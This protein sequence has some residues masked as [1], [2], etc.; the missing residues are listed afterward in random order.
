M[1]KVFALLLTLAMVLSLMAGCGSSSSES[2]A[3]ESTPAETAEAEVSEEEPEEPEAEEP[4]AEEPAAEEPEAPAEE[5]EAPAEEAPEEEAEEE[6]V[7]EEKG[8]FTPASAELPLA[9]N[10]SLTYF[11]ELPGYMSMFNVNSYDDINAF[12]YA[13]EITGIDVKFTIVNSESYATNFQLMVASGDILDMVAGASDQYTSTSAMI[14]DGVALDLMEYQDLL[15]NYF[16]ALDYYSDYWVAALNQEGQMPEAITMADDY[17]VSAGLQT[18]AD[19]LDKLGM[20]A[21]VTYDDLYEVL[22]A[23]KTEFGA[24]HA[25][26]LTGDIVITESS[27]V[28]GLGSVG[29]SV[30]SSNNMW[31]EDGVVK[32]GFLD[33]GFKEYM[34]MLAKWY[35]EGLIAA[36]FATESSDPF[37]SNADAYIQGGN[38]GVWSSQSDNMDAN[39]ASG[40]SLDPD[41]D[42]VAITEP[43]RE[44]GEI[45]HFGSSRIGTAATGKNVA[46]SEDCEDVALACSWIDFWYTEEGI[47]L[48]NYGVE[49]EG[50]TYDEDG[51]PMLSDLVLYNDEFPMIS[52]ATTYYTLACV[53]TVQDYDRTFAAYSAENLAAMDLWTATSDDLYTLPAQVELTTDESSEY[54]SIWSDLS[55]Y[56]S[57]EVFKFVMGE[58]NFDDDW[59]SFLDQ[60]DAMGLQDC[61]AIYQGAYDRYAEAYGV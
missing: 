58:Y 7:E 45:F 53:P 34:E 9:D 19:W 2:S 56:A 22:S 33:D 18:R 52:F 24:D 54:S 43:V 37:A 59:D 8:E 3:A 4:A 55:T 14:E 36:D 13:E 35:S 44:E 48:A 47:T 42:I 26:L 60:L 40:Q 50:L 39:K 12:Q 15:P 38:A 11:C 21:P 49:G 29:Y 23:F 41:Y 57:T 30:D 10:A 5:P 25:L 51:N 28:G 27:I 46:I 32:N 1:K 17:S 20:D 6:P 61:I 16:Y 31:V